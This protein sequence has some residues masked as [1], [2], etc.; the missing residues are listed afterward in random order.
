MYAQ[1]NGYRFSQ[2]TEVPTVCNPYTLTSCL[3]DLME[4]PETRPGRHQDWPRHWAESGTPR[5]LIDLLHQDRRALSVPCALE[6][7]PPPPV[8]SLQRPNAAMLM[9]QT[10]YYTLQ[11]VGRDLRLDYPNREVQ[12]TFAESLLAS[13]DLMY[14]SRL[15]QDLY[16]ALA[17][18]DESGFPR[19]LTTYLY[20]MP[21]DHLQSEHSYTLVMQALCLLL[22]TD[23]QA[24]RHNW[25][26]RSDLTVFLPDRIY[27]F[28]LKYNGTLLAAEAQRDQRNYGRELASRGVLL[29]AFHLNFVRDPGTREPPRIACSLQKLDFAAEATARPSSCRAF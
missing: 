29:Y 26:G 28:E 15:M 4:R 21:Y 2:N 20:N 8:Y 6:Q 10:G 18:S 7:F 14:S 13:C 25:A 3:R 11:G 22:N 1:Y 9:L 12:R 16:G 27:V 19:H 23:S 24:E 17:A 5:F